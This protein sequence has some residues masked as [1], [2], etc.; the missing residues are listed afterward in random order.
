MTAALAITPHEVCLR[1]PR[2]L[3]SSSIAIGAWR[4]RSGNRYVVGIHPLVASEV[5]DLG[6]AVLLAVRRDVTGRGHLLNVVTTDDID[7][8][9]FLAWAIRAGATEIAAHRLAETPAARAALVSDLLTPVEV[10]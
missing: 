3:R 5:E 4:G 2:G 10:L 7:V 8:L 9:A 1:I 6:D